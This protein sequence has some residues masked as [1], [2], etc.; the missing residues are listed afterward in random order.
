MYLE[1]K[2]LINVILVSYY[3][4]QI[5]IVLNYLRNSFYFCRHAY[6]VLDVRDVQVSSNKGA[7]I[8]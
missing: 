4:L 5:K 1:F 6:S 7:K 8:H 2:G 3:S